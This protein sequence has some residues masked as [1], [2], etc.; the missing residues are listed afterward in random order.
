[1]KKTNILLSYLLAGGAL[2]GVSAGLMGGIKLYSTNNE[3]GVY[4]IDVQSDESVET[5]KNQ[6]VYANFRNAQGEKVATFEIAA[7]SPQN[8]GTILLDPKIKS[9]K[10]RF[11]ETEFADWFAENYD[12]QTPIFELKIG[13]MKFVN[14]Y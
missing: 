3:L 8:S 6:L 5:K 13:V 9:A 11:S 1:M 12:R 7:D 14:E 2:T 4:N 10:R